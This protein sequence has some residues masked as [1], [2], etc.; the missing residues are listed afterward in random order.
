MG[1]GRER[2]VSGVKGEGQMRAGLP[3]DAPSS[4]IAC[5]IEVIG[6]KEGGMNALVWLA[7]GVGVDGAARATRSARPRGEWR[8][9]TCIE[10]SRLDFHF[11]LLLITI[12]N[13]SPPGASS[14]PTA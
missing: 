14:A 6:E 7:G 4:V 3:G 11:F 8:R 13:A 1:Q 9:E 5:C 10:S 12:I 2:E